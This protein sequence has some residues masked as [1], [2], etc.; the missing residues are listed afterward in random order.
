MSSWEQIDGKWYKPG[1]PE[2]FD[3]KAERLNVPWVDPPLFPGD[4]Q[5]VRWNGQFSLQLMDVWAH[6][7]GAGIRWL[8]RTF[9]RSDGTID[10]QAIFYKEKKP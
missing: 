2:W 8:A 3:A 6:K 4:M 7:L 10:V 9:P 1:S 5:P